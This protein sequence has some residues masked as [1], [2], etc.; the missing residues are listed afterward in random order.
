MVVG[1]REKPQMRSREPKAKGPVNILHL[2]LWEKCFL[3]HGFKSALRESERRNDGVKTFGKY[4]AQDFLVSQTSSRSPSV[5]QW[6]T[7]KV[8]KSREPIGLQ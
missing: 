3:E 4:Y 7:W 5:L 6:K 2:E 1:R 8:A